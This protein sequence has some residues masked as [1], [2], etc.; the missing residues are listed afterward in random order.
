R[1][2][3]RL[4]LQAHVTGNGHGI[5][6]IVFAFRILVADPAQDAERVIAGKCHQPA[7]AEA[8]LALLRR[9]L[10]LL[11]DCDKLVPM[12]QKP[13]IALWIRRPESKYRY[14]STVCQR[15]TQFRKRLRSH[16]RRIAEY[17]ENIVSAAGDRLARR[18]NGVGCAAPLALLKNLRLWRDPLH[19]PASGI[20]VRSHDCAVVARPWR[21]RGSND[22]RQQ[23]RPAQFMHDLGPARRHS[24][25]LA[26]SEHNGKA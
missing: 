13:A 5:S 22:M 16:Q 12:Q 1:G 11:A 9:G 4:S 10:A 18:K 2:F 19:L 8:D 3:N 23:C 21:L 20:V 14:G 26:G 7:I 6:E 17:N 24:R 15:L 25:A